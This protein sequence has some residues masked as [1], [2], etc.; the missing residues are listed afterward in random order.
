L[1]ITH[2]FETVKTMTEKTYFAYR[3]Y[4]KQEDGEL[5][6]YVGAGSK[7]RAFDFKK[8]QSIWFDVVEKFDGQP[9]VDLFGPVSEADA[10]FME[11]VLIDSLGR[12]GRD[13]GGTLI[14]SYRGM[15][16]P[17]KSA[18]RRVSGRSKM[19]ASRL[20]RLRES[21]AEC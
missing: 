15:K 13:D 10:L 3:H 20:A 12:W 8:R 16:D 14:N 11:R 21:R 9:S 17:E 2:D 18:A 7:R 4:Y 19:S 5:T 1:R 6:F